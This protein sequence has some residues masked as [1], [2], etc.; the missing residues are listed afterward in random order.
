MSQELVNHPAN[1][2]SVWASVVLQ[3]IADMD[4][5]LEGPAARHYIL[6]DSSDGVGSLDWCCS[7]LDLDSNLLRVMCSTREGRKSILSNLHKNARFYTSRP[8]DDDID[9]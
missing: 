7:N 4:N 6:S 1:Y 3:A 8:T 9:D 2:R 5:A